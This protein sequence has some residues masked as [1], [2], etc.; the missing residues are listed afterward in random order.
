MSGSLVGW[1]SGVW[2]AGAW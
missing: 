1:W 2:S